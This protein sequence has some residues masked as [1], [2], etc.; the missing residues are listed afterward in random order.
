MRAKITCT[1][2]KQT[3]T[4]GTEP[5]RYNESSLNEV[6]AKDMNI[7]MREMI[8]E[9]PN[10]TYENWAKAYQKY[11]S[12]QVKPIKRKRLHYIKRHTLDIIRPISCNRNT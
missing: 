4:S 2:R 1:F 3:R 8:K 5:T 6:N 12:Q 9:W 7:A 11:V 10:N